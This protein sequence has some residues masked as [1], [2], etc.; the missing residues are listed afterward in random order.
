[1]HLVHFT[2]PYAYALSIVHDSTFR[3]LTSILIYTALSNAVPFKQLKASMLTREFQFSKADHD[4]QQCHKDKGS[5]V[6]LQAPQKERKEKIYKKKLGE[7][8]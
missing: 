2:G 5:N 6:S 4:R 8:F 1:M 7:Q 3:E